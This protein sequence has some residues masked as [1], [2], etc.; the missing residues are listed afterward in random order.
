VKQILGGAIVGLLL[1]GVIAGALVPALP[2]SARR[3][4]VVCA[5]AVPVIAIAVYVA[6]RMART[7]PR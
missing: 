4:W 5:I 6:A 7:P 3:P 2:P 1:S